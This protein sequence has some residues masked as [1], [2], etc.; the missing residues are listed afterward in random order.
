MIK[1]AQG[2]WMKNKIK[3]RIDQYG[4]GLIYEEIL[5]HI[6]KEYIK[7]PKQ[8]LNVRILSANISSALDVYWSQVYPF[9][10]QHMRYLNYIGF[11]T[12]I[13]RGRYKWNPIQIG[14]RFTKSQYN[15]KKM[16]CSIF[17]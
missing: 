4:N 8:I 1:M 9:V 15:R 3:T 16:I 6:F 12:C 13:K 14:I 7:N 2:E 17:I 5:S 10:C 11:V